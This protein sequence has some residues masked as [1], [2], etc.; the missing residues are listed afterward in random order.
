MEKSLAKKFTDFYV[1]IFQNSIFESQPCAV[2]KKSL[3]FE[4]IQILLAP[5]FAISTAFGSTKK[6]LT[7]FS[8]LQCS[9][10]QQTYQRLQTRYSY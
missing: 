8:R 4:Y 2:N 1:F 7:F 6:P 3:L 9:L 10:T 5:H